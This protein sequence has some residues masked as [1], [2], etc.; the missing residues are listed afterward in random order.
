[1]RLVWF[2]WEEE[3]NINTTLSTSEAAHLVYDEKCLCTM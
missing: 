3:E 1:M 2:P